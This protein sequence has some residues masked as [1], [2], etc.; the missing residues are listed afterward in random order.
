MGRAHGVAVLAVLLLARPAAA[1]SP[2]VAE[3]VARVQALRRAHAASEPT[4]LGIERLLAIEEQPHRRGPGPWL[5]RADDYLAEAEAGRDPYATEARGQ[6]TLRGYRSPISDQLQGYAVYVPPDYDPSRRYPLLIALHGGSSN[7]NLFA[8]LTLGVRIPWAQYRRNWWVVHQPRE[9]PPW[10]VVAPN[11]FGNSMWRYMGERDVLDVLDDVR[12]RYS[13]DEDRVVLHGLSNGGLGSFNI[14]TRHAWRFSAVV[15]LAGAP[16]WVHYVGGHPAA[17]DL[18]VLEPLS[19]WA[20]LEN[21]HNTHLH[22]HHGRTDP[23][24]MRPRYMEALEAQA[25]VLEVPFTLTWYATGHDLVAP[26]HRQGRVFEEEATR[27]REASPDTVTLVTGD[28]RAARQHWVEV[29]RIEG[30][31]AIVGVEARRDGDRI[32]LRT[33]G[34]LRG[35]RLRDVAVGAV[36][37]DGT[38]VSLGGARGVVELVRGEAGWRVGTPPETGKRPGLSGPIGDAMNE[39]LIHVYGTGGAHPEILRETA[40]QGARGWIDNLRGVRQPVVADTDLTPA[41]IAS[42]HLVLYGSPADNA[43]LA[44]I[45]DRLPIRVAAESIVVGGERFEGAQFGVRF[46][47][48]SPL[49]PGRYVVVQGA[50]RPE[51][52]REGNHLPAFLPDWVVYDARRLP[53]R[54]GNL[55]NQHSRH[56]AAGFFDDAWRLSPATPVATAGPGTTAPR[57]RGAR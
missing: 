2:D 36:V 5:A 26:V 6:I 44:R 25:E 3:R 14:G 39:R 45:A 21:A 15:P 19:A 40:E 54:P 34:P 29:T 38:R 50:A 13:V 4:L 56:V 12:A 9:L 53:A 17:R 31:P 37:I 20:L 55:P 28:Y 8:A 57:A 23:G 32:E 51:T 7:G 10:I 11:G 52:V 16:G 41:Q 22:A 35:L 48:P 30:Y 42:A 47:H 27:R 43:V 46:I 24:P 49:A 18:R 33:R 1:Q